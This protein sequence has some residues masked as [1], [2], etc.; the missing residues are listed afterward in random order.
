MTDVQNAENLV[1]VDRTANL[2]NMGLGRRPGS[3]NRTTAIAKAAIEFAAAEIG[4]GERLAVWIK[5]SPG[6]ERVFWSVI[7]PKLLPLQVTG[8]DGEPL[9][10]HP[11]I[12]IPEHLIREALA[13]RLE[14]V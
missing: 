13:R 5:E 8:G 9:I 1:A 11:P 7:F 2:T 10:P 12:E 3:V 4:G 6:N 14:E